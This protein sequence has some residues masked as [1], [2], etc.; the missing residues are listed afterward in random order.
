MLCGERFC[1]AGVYQSQEPLDLYFRTL[2][3]M[4]MEFTLAE[5]LGRGFDTFPSMIRQG[6]FDRVLLRP[7]SAILQVLGS[8]FEL[9]RL[10]R[11]LQ[12]IVMLGYGMTTVMI[13]KDA[14]YCMAL[15]KIMDK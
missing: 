5:I 11:V 12:S 14:L 3:I 2:S 13:Q 1:K 10:G 4:L 15:L 8:K 7:R 9:A 6:T